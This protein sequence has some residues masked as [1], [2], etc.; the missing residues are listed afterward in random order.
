MGGV[1]KMVLWRNLKLRFISLI[2]LV[3]LINST[4]S[5]WILKA[6]EFTGINLGAIG[7]FLSTFMNVIV[8]TALIGYLMN[9]FIIKPIEVM[10]EKMEV[11]EKG[12]KAIRIDLKGQDEISVL[13]QRLNRLFENIES[14]QAMQQNQIN[15]LEEESEKIFNEVTHLTN[16]SSMITDIT[17]E[18]TSETQGQ[19]S[20]YEE[21]ASSAD[22][23]GKSMVEI[24]DQ[25]SS[26]T[27]SFNTMNEKAVKGKDNIQKINSTMENISNEVEVSS[28][29]LVNLADKVEG[30]KEVVSLINQI[31]EQTNLLALNASIEAARAG[32]HG[33][34]FEV[35][36][37][38]VRKLAES[39]VNATKQITETV[40]A[41][42]NDVDD[43]VTRSKER[44]NAILENTDY[45]HGIGDSF[46]EI[47]KEVLQNSELVHKINQN[48][49]E[50][51]GATQ[52]VASTLDD[53]TDKNNKT[54]DK[55]VSI[56]KQ[57]NDHN[58]S[59]LEIR[60]ATE[61]LQ[62]IFI[63]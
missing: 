43:S 3:L 23:I 5:S 35:V 12:D 49:E 63:K 18:I 25:L 33:R 2:V 37:N 52:E 41:I 47:T 42:I 36:A 60:N 40:N 4:I 59:M 21:T 6:I 48:S 26:L 19:L 32:E 13:G 57:L 38:E 11:F 8:A 61:R 20:L 46:E 55:L 58:K 45:I 56:S 31:S 16:N 34:G 24:S 39:S 1:N 53:I 30:I 22:S 7:V 27:L 9:I 62:E 54:T 44:V 10:K 51:T 17:D 50:I 29:D 15:R 28:N 14:F